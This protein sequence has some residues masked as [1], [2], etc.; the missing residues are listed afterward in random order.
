MSIL[1]K[2]NFLSGLKS[3]TVA[4]IAVLGVVAKLLYDRGERLEE[5]LENANEKVKA[6][7]KFREN[8]RKVRDMDFDDML[9]DAN[10]MFPP[11][12]EKPDP[13]S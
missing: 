10:S 9:D 2:F 4:I 5:K 12:G 7:K 3:W 1:G 6:Q 11:P 8:R 13:G